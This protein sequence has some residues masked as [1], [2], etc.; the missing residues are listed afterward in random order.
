[1]GG[2]GMGLGPLSMAKST[3]IMAPQLQKNERIWQGTEPL[4]E[5]KKCQLDK[6][7]CPPPPPPRNRI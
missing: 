2:A 3:G 1:M 6:Q 5:S 4:S 7:K